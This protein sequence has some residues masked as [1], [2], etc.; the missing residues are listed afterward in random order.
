MQLFDDGA[1]G[2]RRHGDAAPEQILRA[3]I[4][5]FHHRRHVW[6]GRRPFRRAHRQRHHLAVPA[7]L[8]R[9]RDRQVVVV[10]AAGHHLGEG[11]DRTAERNVLHVDAG[12]DLE[13]LRRPVRGGS[14]PGGGEVQHA[15][16][17]LGGGDE[18]GERPPAFRGRGDQH[19]R[20]HAEHGHRNEIVHGIVGQRLVERDGGA[21][22][23]GQQ[24]ERV[25]VG[26]GLGCRGGSDRAAG[27][28]AVLDHERLADLPS[29]L[30]EHDARDGIAGV[31]GAHRAHRHDRAVGPILRQRGR[32]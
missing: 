29:H 9:R 26:I 2:L 4:A 13:P 27:A 19:A 31:A 7:R 12:R 10:D 30:I 8:Q 24:Q 23:G 28:G 6:Q 32:R 14:E 11:L 25:A 18:V 16:V 5:R 15:R 20:L 1:R 21:L 22:R 17:R 3:G